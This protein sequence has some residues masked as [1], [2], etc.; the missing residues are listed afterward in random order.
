VCVIQLVLSLCI[1]GLSSTLH[2]LTYPDPIFV[3]ILFVFFAVFISLYH[4]ELRLLTL[5]CRTAYI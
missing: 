3:I 4:I 2:Y 5:S 1:L